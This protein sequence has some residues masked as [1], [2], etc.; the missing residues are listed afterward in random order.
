MITK[1]KTK[2]KAKEVTHMRKT[3]ITLFMV[4]LTVVL[5]YGL[6]NAVAT[7][8]CSNC[9]TMHNSQ[10][11][12]IV[13]AADPQGF[14][15]IE[16]CY[17][18]HT[19]GGDAAAPKIDGTNASTG[20]GSGSSEDAGGTILGDGSN[21]NSR[22]DAQPGD[23]FDM[24]PPGYS[25]SLT[26]TSKNVTC[27]GEFGCH[28]SHGTTPGVKNMHHDSTPSYRYLYVQSGNAGGDGTDVDGLRSTTWEA[29]GATMANHNIYKA[30][31]DGI[32]AFCA[33]CH[34][35]FHGS[36]NTGSASPFVRHPTDATA[37]I[38]NIDGSG[39]TMTD[40]IVD[41]TPF[42]FAS[43]S[44]MSTT[45]MTGYTSADGKAMCLSCHKAHGS[46]EPDLLRFDYGSMNAGDG[47]N[48]KGCETCHVTQ[49]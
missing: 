41:E 15:L 43:I 11:G 32:S 47:T 34:G 13:G 4:L 21:V 1:Q 17:A 26:W 23:S 20:K 35:G 33:N 9:H 27:A 14:L 48:Q 36:A 10:N 28:G 46:A 22:H 39:L 44:S 37:S 2:F 6:A 19:S 5:T 42:A 25:G 12:T 3:L 7:G 49:Q 40:D 16:S 24:T 45:T 18:C 31:A 30:A 8:V 29:G 38:S